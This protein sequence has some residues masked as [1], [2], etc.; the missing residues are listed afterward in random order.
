MKYF[1]SNIGYSN[2]FWKLFRL[3]Y[4]DCGSSSRDSLPCLKIN[5]GTVQFFLYFTFSFDY[6]AW[7]GVAQRLVIVWSGLNQRYII[8][9]KLGM[10]INNDITQYVTELKKSRNAS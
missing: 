9:I 4:D 3:E 5:D 8:R 1:K 10:Y 7:S 2:D 6:V